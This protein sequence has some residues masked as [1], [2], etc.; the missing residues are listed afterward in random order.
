MHPFIRSTDSLEA[1]INHILWREMVLASRS[2]GAEKYVEKA[3]PA[4][5][6]CQR[7]GAKRDASLLPTKN[8]HW[9]ALL[10]FTR[11]SKER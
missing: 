5:H 11:Q 3:G 10:K 8:W 1:R 2:R 4:M 7:I 9:R 6:A